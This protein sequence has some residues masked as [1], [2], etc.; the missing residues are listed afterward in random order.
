MK[1]KLNLL[2]IISIIFVIISM[3]YINI[4]NVYAQQKIS[5][6]GGGAE[7]KD[8]YT[9]INPNDYKPTDPT[10]DDA[11]ELVDKIGVILGAIRNIS[12][13]ISVIIISIIGI[14]YIF[15]SVEEKASYKATMIPYIIG[16]V[17][18]VS[19]TTIITFIY[20][21]VH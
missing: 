4:G 10:T 18:A 14:K 11:V 12:V 2:K 20:N 13:M 19:G 3:F 5:Q 8:P 17:M 15:G 16:C 21:I 7:V 1:K 9:S 6:D